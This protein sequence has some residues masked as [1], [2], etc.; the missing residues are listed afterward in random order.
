MNERLVRLDDGKLYVSCEIPGTDAPEITIMYW[1]TG[2]RAWD[3]RHY[4]GAGVW[5]EAGFP[6]QAQGNGVY[7]VDFGGEGYMRTRA[8]VR[9]VDGGRT[10]SAKTETCA[11]QCPRV[12]HGVETQWNGVRGYWEKYL[13]A[14]GWVIA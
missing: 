2:M 4:C 7:I 6:A 9:L 12:R 13:K 8:S 14:K 1:P 5:P 11:I 10:T 3:A